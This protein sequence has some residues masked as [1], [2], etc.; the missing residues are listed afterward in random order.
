MYLC[1]DAYIDKIARKFKLCDSKLRVPSIP[2]TTIPLVKHE[3]QASQEEI[4]AYQERVGSLMYIAVM[5]RPD[6]ARAATQLARFLTNPSPEHLAAADQCIPLS[7]HDE[8][9][10]HHL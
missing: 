2:I 7:L 8:I 1:Q 4:K 3:G 10:R 9:P 6:I 5:T